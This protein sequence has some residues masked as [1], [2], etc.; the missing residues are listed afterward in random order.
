MVGLKITK[1][2]NNYKSIVGHI[3]RYLSHH[4]CLSIKEGCLFATLYITK[5]HIVENKPHG[6]WSILVSFR[7]IF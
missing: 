2:S 1:P 5:K 3:I 7:G 6:L 4:E